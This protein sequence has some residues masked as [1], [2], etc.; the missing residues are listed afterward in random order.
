MVTTTTSAALDNIRNSFN[1]NVDVLPLFGPEGIRT[2]VYGLFRDDDGQFVGRKSVTRGY[3][4]HQTSD[5]VAIAE[6]VSHVFDAGDIET[7]CHWNQGHWVS[8]A[9]SREYRLN[10]FDNASD[11]DDA[12]FPRLLINAGYNG[13]AFKAS[14]GFYRDM[15]RNLSIVREAGESITRT[16]R[17]THSLDSR[18]QDLIEDLRGLRQGWTNTVETIRRMSE[19]ETN[20]ADFIREVFPTPEAPT[21]RQATIAENRIDAIY[22]R[23]ARESRQLGFEMPN[24][25]N[26]YRANGWLLFNAVQGYVQHDMSRRGKPGQFDRMLS[27]LEEPVVD[28]AAELVLAV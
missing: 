3:V 28:R 22:N 17:H 11:K 10:V 14:C 26:G 18:I 27:A 19:V 8:V 15:C 12:I 5:V 24:R 13:R 9:P 23:L 21:Q 7:K 4:P 2:G 20:A 25:N 1:F 6:A 16:I